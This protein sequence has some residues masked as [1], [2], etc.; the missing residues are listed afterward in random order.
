MKK[1]SERIVKLLQK[2]RLKISFA[3]S[4]TGGL[5]ASTIT[6]ISGSS[7]VFTLG[8]VTYS[9]QAKINI[10]KVSKNIIK[11]YGAVSAECCKAMVVKLSKISEAN[12]NV[13]ITGIAGPNGGT[14]KKP[15]GLVYIGLKKGN[16][17]IA[18]R[19][20]NQEVA[21]ISPNYRFF[22]N[23]STKQIILDAAAAVAWA[24]NNIQ[25]YGGNEKLIFVSGHSAGGYLTSMVG[26][27]KAWLAKY[28]IDSDKIA[29]LI[30][31]SG[32]A[33]THFTVREEMGIA[34]RNKVIVDSMAP[35][36]HIRKNAPPYIIITG[37]RD[38]ELLGRYE[39][40]AYMARMMRLT[41]HQST[42]IYELDGY[43]HN[44]VEPALPLLLK[45]VK[46]QTRKILEEQTN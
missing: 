27:D 40:N 4:C 28:K 3:E 34:D 35:L 8:L 17:Y 12:I 39:E 31:F 36:Y 23:I 15:V 14:K 6:K 24:F 11:K 22:P 45:F 19:L 10:L 44:M 37:H 5:L 2:K 7:K 32:H 20:K 38:L 42:I 33:I 41:G 18:D 29:G 21:I 30:P 1:L 25:D 13:S 26:L 46:E 43:G 16:K 9:N